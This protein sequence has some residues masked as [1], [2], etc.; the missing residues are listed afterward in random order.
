MLSC[1]H[2]E[3]LND[4]FNKIH[5][6]FILGPTDSAAGPGPGMSYVITEER[7][8]QAKDT[9]EHT[10][11]EMNKEQKASQLEWGRK[12]GEWQEAASARWAG[13]HRWALAGTL[14]ATLRWQSH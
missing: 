14:A 12:K 13:C 2:L 11:A 3:I 1:H 6:H 5:F 8:L 7:D 9:S 10:G 4:F